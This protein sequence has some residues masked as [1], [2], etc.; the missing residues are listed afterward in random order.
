MS[1]EQ[2]IFTKED[3]LLWEKEVIDIKKFGTYNNKIP[4]TPKVKINTY[5]QHTAI[6]IPII[7]QEKCI[8]QFGDKQKL[9]NKL[10]RNIKQ[11]R[12]V[13][14]SKLDLHGLTIIEAN[15]ILIEFLNYCLIE[16]HEKLLIITGKGIHSINKSSLIRNYI[17]EWI[18]SWNMRSH[19]KYIN[20]AHS[21]HGGYGAFYIFLK[22]LN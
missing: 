15:K 21:T 11:G 17:F 10:K 13:L 4:A 18:K 7:S 8:I 9:N 12:I 2:D 16:K 22:G 14:D 5:Y 19:I 6:E 1:H 20:Y 3:L